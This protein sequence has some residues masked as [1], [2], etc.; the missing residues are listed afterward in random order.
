MKQ[1]EAPRCRLCEKNHWAREGCYGMLVKENQGERATIARAGERPGTGALKDSAQVKAERKGATAQPDTKREG[2][3]VLKGSTPKASGAKP[4]RTA[5]T[6]RADPC[7]PAK[8]SAD[9]GQTGKARRVAPP[10]PG[11]GQ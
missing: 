11:R 7:T 3:R 4:T 8:A 5:S 6:E 1:M 2:R 10:K 9:N